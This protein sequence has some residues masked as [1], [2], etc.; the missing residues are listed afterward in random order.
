MVW[1]DQSRFLH[2]TGPRTYATEWR[3]R[4]CC[5]GLLL[6][7]RSWFCGCGSWPHSPGTVCLS[8]TSAWPHR[9]PLPPS[10]V[11]WSPEQFEQSHPSGSAFASRACRP[12]HLVWCRR[13]SRSKRS[14]WNTFAS[15]GHV[16]WCAFHRRWTSSPNSG[17]RAPSQ[18]LAGS[19]DCYPVG[20]CGWWLSAV[21]AWQ[22]C[23]HEGWG[24]WQTS[25]SDGSGHVWRCC[26]LVVRLTA[27]SWPLATPWSPA[28]CGTQETC[29]A[30]SHQW[31]S[32][33][34]PSGGRSVLVP[35]ALKSCQTGFLAWSRQ[36]AVC[37]RW[38]ESIHAAARRSEWVPQQALRSR[39]SRPGVRGKCPPPSW[40]RT[41]RRTHQL[42]GGST[43]WCWG[44]AAGKSRHRLGRRTEQPL[45]CHQAA[46]A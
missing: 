15:N 32:T 46:S 28:N 42:I 11:R 22:S 30:W 21:K 19:V 5:T 23:S 44:S 40:S 3:N 33:L 18:A 4:R 27:C 31:S 38:G 43:S 26:P 17:K 2:A 29:R 16:G 35:S 25:P 12:I 9:P 37:P 14:A 10:E 6:V 36:P 39:R 41:P 13:C 24:N 7:R 20:L 34:S 8:W 1:L 45:L